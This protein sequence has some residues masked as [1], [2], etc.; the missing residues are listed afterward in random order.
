VQEQSKMRGSFKLIGACFTAGLLAACGNGAKGG[1]MLPLASSSGAGPAY[2]TAAQLGLWPRSGPAVRVCGPAAPGHARCDAWIRTDIHGIGPDNVPS[3]FAPADL[4]KAYA[5]IKASHGKGKGIT[6]AIVVAYHWASAANDLATYRKQWGLPP[7]LKGC[8]TQKSFTK[9]SNRTW[10]RE[11]ALDLDMVSAICPNCKIIA[12]EAANNGYAE[13]TTAENFAT[14]NAKYVSNSWSGDEDSAGKTH[15]GS[16][17]VPGV[18]ITAATG[19]YGYYQKDGSTDAQWPA[20]L[21]SVTGVGGTTLSSLSPRVETAWTGA[22]SACSMIYAQP[23]FQSGINTGCSNRAQ[24]DVSA[25]ADPKTGV[26][27]YDTKWQVLGGTSAASPII[28]ALF[29]L[30]GKTSDNNNPFLYSNAASLYDVTS[31]YNGPCGAPLCNAGC[32]WDGPTGLGSPNALIPRPSPTPVPNCS[33][34]ETFNYTGA[35]QNFTVPTG[36]TKVNIY[37]AGAGSTFLGGGVS[38]T[39]PVTPGEVLAVFVGG[40]N[41]LGSGGFN[42][43]GAGASGGASG[44]GGSGGAGAS[45]VRQGG[46]GLGNRVVVAGGA[47]GSGSCGG[48]CQNS[49]GYGGDGGGLA[50]SGGADGGGTTPGGGIE[51]GGGSQSAAGSGGAGGSSSKSGSVG[52]AGAGGSAGAGGGAGAG[53]AGTGIYQAGG[54]G[55]GGGGGY[56]GGGGGGGGGGGPYFGGGGGGG[57]GGS[58]YIEPNATNKN[59]YENGDQGDGQITISW[60][61]GSSVVHK[62]AQRLTQRAAT[63]QRAP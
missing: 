47:G 44:Y 62:N 26:A 60:G 58:G 20:I 19:D 53:G 46:S 52:G 8:F 22:G 1:A 54:G 33:G 13:M 56:Y 24:A 32:G 41:S 36:V 31:G 23:S 16:Y 7:C 18:M 63:S 3:G 10:E 51:G 28:A 43:G 30:M 34:I 38:A 29:A 2:A 39:I 6:V 45:D 61:G 57:G 5:L 4:Q 27:V 55:G 49:G 11:E 48:G 12:V 59:Y 37:A 15:N 50:G 35:Q 40:T 17:N 42:G 21:S 25:V 9:T 14:A